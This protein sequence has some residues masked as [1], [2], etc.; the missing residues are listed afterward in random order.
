MTAPRPSLLRDSSGARLS[1][2]SAPS[3]PSAPTTSIAAALPCSSRTASGQRGSAVVLVRRP[4]PFFGFFQRAMAPGLSAM[5]S[6]STGQRRLSIA[7][8]ARV[9]GEEVGPRGCRAPAPIA[10]LLTNC[11]IARGLGSIR[12][13]S[14]FRR[15]SVFSL[16]TAVVISSAPAARLARSSSAESAGRDHLFDFGLVALAGHPLHRL[17]DQL[18]SGVVGAGA[19]SASSA[20]R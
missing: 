14:F 1:A 16:A 9:S 19:P 20:S 18:R 8:R 10:T 7:Q 6:A 12:W 17:F 13:P 5:N 15:C 11:F 3:S 2:V 4:G